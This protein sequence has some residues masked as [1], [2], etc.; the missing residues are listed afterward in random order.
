MTKIM[1]AMKMSGQEPNLFLLHSKSGVC[2]IG[3]G[4]QGTVNS[5]SYWRKLQFCVHA[6]SQTFSLRFSQFDL[7]D[8]NQL[9]CWNWQ[10]WDFQIE[11]AW[12]VSACVHS[13]YSDKGAVTG[14][15]KEE[16]P[17][18][19]ALS[20]QVLADRWPPCCSLARTNVDS[21]ILSSL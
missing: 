8:G 17:A 16:A 10:R 1:S 13:L 12:W 20:S 18:N 19:R 4:S 15:D 6:L 3:Q 5:I 2:G 11:R 21:A 14:T 7:K 9:S